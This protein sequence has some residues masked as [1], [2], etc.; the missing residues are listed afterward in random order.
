MSS[1]DLV[2]AVIGHDIHNDSGFS[3]RQERNPVYPEDPKPD[4]PPPALAR[5]S[6]RSE[7]RRIDTGLELHVVNHSA[8]VTMQA[9]G[10]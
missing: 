5:S 7:E 1:G 4:A 2:L 8:A 3:T 6:F 10:S 9:G